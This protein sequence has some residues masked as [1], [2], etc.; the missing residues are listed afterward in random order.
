MA[1][2]C[3]E[4]ICRGSRPGICARD[5]PLMT[6]SRAARSL[7]ST[8]AKGRRPRRA[9]LWAI[10]L[11]QAR[12][13]SPK[14]PIANSVGPTV[15]EDILILGTGAHRRPTWFIQTLGLPKDVI[16]RHR[17]GMLHI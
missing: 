3:G 8:P 4:G 6:R 7:N 10:V 17:I 5:W 14:P 12:G 16:G 11:V 13:A 1:R 2:L 15:V 9:A